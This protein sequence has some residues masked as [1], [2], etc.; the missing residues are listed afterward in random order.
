MQVPLN[1]HGQF[2]GGDVVFV[3]G[4]GVQRP[5]RQGCGMSHDNSVV[6]GVTTMARGVR[7]AMF[8]LRVPIVGGRH[9]VRSEANAM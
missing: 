3:T 9:L 5:A 6:H 7:H 4:E 1:E 8:L 2:D